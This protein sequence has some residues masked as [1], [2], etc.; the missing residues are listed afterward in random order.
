MATIMA[1]PCFQCLFFQFILGAVSVC[2]LGGHYGRYLAATDAVN[3]Q[4]STSTARFFVVRFAQIS[5]QTPTTSVSQE[6]RRST[7]E[8]RSSQVTRYLFENLS[9]ISCLVDIHSTEYQT[10]MVKLVY[11][12]EDTSLVSRF[13]EKGKFDCPV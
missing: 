13:V 2:I 3:S 9:A 5:H 7:A 1:R 8:L 12:N 11:E 6:R 10:I 4:Q